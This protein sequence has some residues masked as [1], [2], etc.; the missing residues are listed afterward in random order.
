MR[1]VKGLG[2]HVTDTQK[3]NLQRQRNTLQRKIDAWRTTQ[4]LYMPVVPGMLSTVTSSSPSALENPEYTKLW[5]P[6][7]IGDR[8][9]HYRLRL[10]EWELRLAQAH[11]ALEELR[12]CLRIRSSLL[13]YKKEWVRGQGANTRAQNALERVIARQAACTGRYHA[14]WDALDAL[15]QWVGKIGWQRTLQRLEDDDIRP[16]IDPDVLPGQGRR[17]LTWIWTMSGVDTDGDGT[18]E[19]GKSLFDFTLSDILIHV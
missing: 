8:Q 15:A 17:K 11:D 14:A 18:D 2:N 10:N 12:Q 16:L 7:A 3:G 4:A 1:F 6:S 13:T 5:L 19:D 9:C